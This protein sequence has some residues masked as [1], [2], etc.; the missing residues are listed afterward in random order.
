MT[1]KSVNRSYWKPFFRFF[2]ALVI[3][4]VAF[5]AI[6]NFQQSEGDEPT[7]AKSPA[8]KPP[9][10]SASGAWAA[11]LKI[12]APTAPPKP[13][14]TTRKF[15]VQVIDEKGLPVEGA[16]VFRIVT[17]GY[18]HPANWLPSRGWSLTNEKGICTIELAI[19]G[20]ERD[21]IQVFQRSKACVGNTIVSADQKSDKVLI[22]VRPGTKIQGRVL[23]AAEI[24]HDSKGIWTVS[25]I[26][27]DGFRIMQ[28]RSYTGEYCFI[29]PKGNY[30]L[31]AY[32]ELVA[33]QEKTF[34][35][36]GKQL[37]LEGP[38]LSLQPRT[39]ALLR[40]KSAPKIRGLTEWVNTKPISLESCKGKYV[41]LDFW[42][43][44]CGI[45]IRDMP[46]LV[47]LCEEAGSD[48]L[49]LITLHCSGSSN[50]VENAKKYNEMLLKQDEGAREVLSKIPVGL[51]RREATPDTTG[52]SQ[53]SSTKTG[54]D[55]GVYSFP[56]TI[57]I[58]PDGKVI[59]KINPS[60]KPHREWV[61]NLINK[62]A[63]K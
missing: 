17:I 58:D 15:Q 54:T 39:F 24:E 5:L 60:H 56:M 45:C 10:E 53:R 22:T 51:L 18:K 62:K 42:G 63:S 16:E 41:L 35:I 61:L 38:N 44:W 12:P 2:A 25:E 59:R 43:F 52:G 32:G 31:K 49:Q 4:S 37:Q 57:L 11:S 6:S 9:V 28:C 20:K 55:Y 21:L 30:K 48:K 14:W 26:Y 47:S 13:K 27:L 1:E 40:G 46:D 29:L 33:E 8:K 7:K 19:E 23:P 34:S 50:L 36:D 3:C